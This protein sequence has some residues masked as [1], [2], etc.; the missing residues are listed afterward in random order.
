VV[1]LLGKR[2]RNEETNGVMWGSSG[3]DGT[4]NGDKKLSQQALEAL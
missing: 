2:D 1:H 3:Y 4:T